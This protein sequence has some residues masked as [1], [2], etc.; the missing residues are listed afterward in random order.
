MTYTDAIQRNHGSGEV[1]E[2]R[3]ED[4]DLSGPPTAH[5]WEC[6]QPGHECG[7]R[8]ADEDTRNRHEKFAHTGRDDWRFYGAP[9]GIIDQVEE[10]WST[11]ENREGET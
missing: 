2:W 6:R 8:F 5:Y 1:W 7:E 10:R 3:G 11:P 4:V 9:L